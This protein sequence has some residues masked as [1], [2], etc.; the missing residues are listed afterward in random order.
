M[1]TTA[2][3]R[4]FLRHVQVGKVKAAVS[5]GSRLPKTTRFSEFKTRFFWQ[6]TRISAMFLFSYW[7]FKK[8]FAFKAKYLYS[9]LQKTK[10]EILLA[11]VS[12]C[13]I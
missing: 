6:K 10:R 7:R 9:F 11:N 1:S 3:G 8:N 13:Q 5:P 4:P 12:E 2:R